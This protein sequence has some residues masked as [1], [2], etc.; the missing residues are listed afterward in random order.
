MKY[1]LEADSVGEKQVPVDAYYGV[2]SLRGKENFPITGQ[3]LH[4]NLVE[5]LAQ[6][7]KACAK[8]NFKAGVMS[9]KVCDAIVYA[10]DA[11]LD[12]KYHDQFMTDPIQGGAGTTANMNANEVIANIANEHLG[13]G[14]G[15][16]EFVH[17]ND[18]VNMG[19][20]TNDV[21]P[22]A[23][24]IASLHLAEQLL[25]ELDK[26]QAA[27]EKKAEEFDDVL[28]MGRTQLQDAVPIRLGQEFK[29]YADVL[30]RDRVRIEQGMAGIKVVN[31]GAT[32]IGTGIN[33]DL[34]YFDHIVPILADITGLD[35]TQAE[36]L[37]DGTSNLDVLVG[38]SS[39]LKTLAVNLSKMASDLRLMGSGP[40]T[41]VGDLHLPPRQNGSSIMPGKVNPVIP[42]VVNQVAYRVIGND[43]TITMCAEA[44]QL[45]LNPNEPVLFY[46]L[47]ES[48]EI[49][50]H[51]ME[52]FR[53]NCVDG[54]QA[55]REKLAADVEKSIGILT[56]L[57]PH[58]GYKEAAA[59]AKIALESDTPVR[60]LVLEREVL[61]EDELKEILDPFNMTKPGIAAEHLIK[62]KIDK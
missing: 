27:L 36:D 47:Y 5:A 11:I 43:V 60:Q 59:I 34:D 45:Q 1:R 32:A 7:K 49:L 56:A 26:L 62:E 40:R 30:K 29:A 46:S 19:Q 39:A 35:L 6:V 53:L 22:T 8:A 41:M 48:L 58:I 15:T 42:E 13:G 17:P 57:V 24:K 9:E 31:M 28:K 33:V 61:S 16:Y 50:T 10:S 21:F 55:N 20:S 2:Q 51:G 25:E 52:T 38:L 12:G 44:G 37:V 23:G 54:V 18:H 14:L 3:H 4:K